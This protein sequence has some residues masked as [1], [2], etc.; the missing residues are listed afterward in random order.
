MAKNAALGRLVVAV[1]FAVTL[2][3]CQKNAARFGG[4]R[5]R[6]YWPAALVTEYRSASAIRGQEALLHVLFVPVFDLP[7]TAFSGIN[8]GHGGTDER[9][10]IDV[11]Y[12]VG[13]GQS[14]AAQPISVHE[15]RTVA[16]GERS[17][18][19]ADGNVFLA[20]VSGGG[21]V[22]MSQLKITRNDPNESS[23]SIVREIQTALPQNQR[24][25]SLKGGR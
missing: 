11:S 5:V 20:Y 4:H 2:L 18:N 16:V 13:P 15:K 22:T 8:T 24:I 19:L 3:S 12:V 1:L 23:D 14:I 10:S 17:F 6:V 9:R 7:K 21:F 25:Q